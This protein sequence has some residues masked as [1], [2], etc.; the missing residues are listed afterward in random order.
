[1]TDDSLSR[2]DRL[3]ELGQVLLLLK[4]EKAF[5]GWPLEELEE[6]TEDVDERESDSDD[7]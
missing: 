5:V 3:K 7:E 4:M 1:M 6:A 2:D